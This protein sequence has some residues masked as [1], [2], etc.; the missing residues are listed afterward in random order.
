[1]FYHAGG[2]A[3]QRLARGQ[4]TSCP[5]INNDVCWAQHEKRLRPRLRSK[6]DGDLM[7]SGVHNSPRSFN[8]INMVGQTF[9]RLTVIERAGTSKD[10]KA[11]WLCQCAC[12]K[13]TTAS[14][15]DIRSGHTR[16]CGCRMVEA[17]V[18]HN[19]KHAGSGTRLYSIWKDMR[20][21]CRKH[22]HYAG[23]GI[24]VCP[25]WANWPLFRDWALAHGYRA[26]LTIERVDN[27][28]NYT[29]ENC[30][31]ATRAV[32]SRNRSFS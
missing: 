27:S 12:G 20:K 11:L 32:Q 21:R 30:T 26:D 15:K 2:W 19:A 8:T 23:R 17:T 1:M 24:S 3:P 5:A 6:P 13:T 22:P 16:S 7:T 31:W 28:G 14:G 10:R 25:Q 29:P 9:D 4:K 18:H